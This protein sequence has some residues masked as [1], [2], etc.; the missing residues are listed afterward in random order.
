MNQM[1]SDAD[2]SLCSTE[3]FGRTIPLCLR[4]DATH[5][6]LRSPQRENAHSL[7]H[8]SYC[9]LSFTDKDFLWPIIGPLACDERKRIDDAVQECTK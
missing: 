5:P 2:I 4:A 9:Q 7:L 6:N 3:S 1:E 8:T